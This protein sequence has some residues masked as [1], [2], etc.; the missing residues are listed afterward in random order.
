MIAFTSA[1]T[2]P[3]RRFSASRR[4]CSRPR[5]RCRVARPAIRA[6]YTSELQTVSPDISHDST[7]A[8]VSDV[9]K[10][11]RN[12]TSIS[13]AIQ[14]QMVLHLADSRGMARLALVESFGKV[15]SAA[16]PILITAL[17]T[18]PNPV[19]RRSCGKALAKIGDSA[20]T[21]S[22]LHAL[23]YDDDTV[24]RSSAAGALAKM[25]A[26]AVPKLLALISDPQ[27]SMTAKGHAAWAIS[28]M[29]G[30]AGDALFSSL[31]HPNPDVRTAVVSALG[32]VAIGDAL[33]AM[34]AGADDDW[35]D[36][37]NDDVR[38]RAIE[39][40][41]KALDDESAQVRAEAVTALANAGC[42]G[43]G[44]RI[45]QFLND[46]DAELRRCAALA[47]M[48]I[49][50]GKFVRILRERQEQ[51]TVKSVRSVFRLAADSL[52]QSIEEEDDWV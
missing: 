13:E 40:M 34:G 10:Q 51:E 23:V 8:L 9:T 2:L 39:A 20:A 50:D 46:G 49:S 25:G 47:L 42:K 17:K 24:T 11:L 1:P 36:G 38:A 18:C 4:L 5:S 32:A 12:G 19:V 45:A 22:L 30:A 37:T 33:P 21:D 3:A 43:D 31:Q 27:V 15:G 28:F 41:R 35:Q 29:Q 44:V 16:V 52:E 14:Q 7:D 26:V 48:K 6:T